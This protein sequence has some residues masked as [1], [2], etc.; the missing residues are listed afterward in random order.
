MNGVISDLQRFSLNDGPGIRTTVFLKGCNMR[1]AWCHNPETLSMKNELAV[2]PDKC[3]GCMNCV[4]ACPS[5][6]RAAGSGGGLCFDPSRCTAC[7]KCAELC[8]PGALENSARRVDTD[9]VM[10]EIL[11]DREYYKESGGGVTLSGGEAMCQRDFSG[12]IIE[13]CRVEGISCAVETNLAYDFD[14][15]EALMRKLD[16]VMFDIKLA[17]AGEH[18][19]W[20]GID[21]GIILENVRHLD[22]LGIQLICRTPLIPGVTDTMDNLRAIAGILGGMKNLRYWE[23][24]NFNPLG[25]G[26]YEALR[27][28]NPFT[29]V[30]PLTPA[31]L[32]NI[33]A[34]L[35]HIGMELRIS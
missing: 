19:K 9:Y 31:E 16:L 20:T 11:Q 8:F 33:R 24:L 25:G 27:M 10:G 28:R 21:N 14:D 13:R 34:G 18:V 7:V 23:L 22:S 30:S 1:C 5:G 4:P 15:I 29:A 2:R 35:G 12:S 3:I 6:A 17:D 26:K 32:E